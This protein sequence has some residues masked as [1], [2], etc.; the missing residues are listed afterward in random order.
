MRQDFFEIF[1]LLVGQKNQGVLGEK[2]GKGRISIIKPIK[3][4]A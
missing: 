1:L 2:V 4:L 3:K